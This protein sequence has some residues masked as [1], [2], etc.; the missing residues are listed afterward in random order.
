MNIAV[1]GYPKDGA[2]RIAATQRATMPY[3]GLLPATQWIFININR[4][5]GLGV[6]DFE[7]GWTDGDPDAPAMFCMDEHGRVR[8][9]GR[10]TGGAVGTV[11]VTLPYGFRPA[12]PQ[13]FVLSNADSGYANVE[14]A[15]NGE[16]T[17]TGIT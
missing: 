15:P 9:R 7:N 17:V 4:R 3:R 14:L 11:F 13:S 8:L 10:I 2:T 12:V 6:L 1:R 5:N 16:A